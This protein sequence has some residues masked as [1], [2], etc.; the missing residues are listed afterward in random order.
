MCPHPW[1]GTRIY[2]SDKMKFR[3]VYMCPDPLCRMCVEWR[4][5]SVLEYYV[6]AVIVDCDRMFTVNLLRQDILG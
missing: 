1:S 4:R 6:V 5:V 2:I 3:F